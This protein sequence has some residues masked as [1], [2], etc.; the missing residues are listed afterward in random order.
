MTSSGIGVLGY[1]QL[2][3]RVI[4]RKLPPMPDSESGEWSDE[5]A[6]ALKVW[7]ARSLR[8]HAVT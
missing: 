6:A 3:Y 5:D 8:L 4:K 7:F 1:C 2:S